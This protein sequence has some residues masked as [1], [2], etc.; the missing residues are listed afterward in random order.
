VRRSNL[1]PKEKLATVIEL[2]ESQ[3]MEKLVNVL[4]DKGLV[5][6]PRNQFVLAVELVLGFNSTAIVEEQEE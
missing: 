3:E 5:L 6:N 4:K 1:S 2:M